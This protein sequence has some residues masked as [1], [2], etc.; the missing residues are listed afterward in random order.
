MSANLYP[1]SDLMYGGCIL[2]RDKTLDQYNITDGCTLHIV[3]RRKRGIVYFVAVTD[4]TRSHPLFSLPSA[5]IAVKYVPL[6][7]GP[8]GMTVVF[9]SPTIQREVCMTHSSTNSHCECF[10]A[11]VYTDSS[12]H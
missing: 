8:E 11:V 5:F 12:F 7:T 6:P 1:T 10:S 2:Q 4:F 9:S 3:Q